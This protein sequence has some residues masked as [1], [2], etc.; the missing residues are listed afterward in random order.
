M[1][2]LL[3]CIVIYLLISVALSTC[4]IIVL[5]KKHGYIK[6]IHIIATII[7]MP[8]G[9]LY[10]IFSI[11]MDALGRFSEKQFFKK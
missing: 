5:Y 6:G 7:T 8:I 2:L 11:L 9:P 4:S 1:N 3:I 10:T